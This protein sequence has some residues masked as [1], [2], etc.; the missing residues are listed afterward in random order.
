[1][2]EE[3]APVA[4]LCRE[5]AKIG[6]SVGMIDARP[7]AVIRA[8]TRPSEWITVGVAG[9]LFEWRGDG[10]RHSVRDPAGAAVRILEQISS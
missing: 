4:A 7:A 5:S 3:L 8:R 10:N 6:M 2:P 9:E 1:M